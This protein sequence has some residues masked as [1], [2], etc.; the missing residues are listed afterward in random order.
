M[1]LDINIIKELVSSHIYH[2]GIDYYKNNLVELVKFNENYIEAFVLGTTE[3]FVTIEFNIN[4]EINA[5]CDCSYEY[6]CKHIVAVLLTARDHYPEKTD[7]RE[8][9]HPLIFL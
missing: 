7:P 2:R 1:Y 4:G 5:E 8:K 6:Q 9:S 3:Y